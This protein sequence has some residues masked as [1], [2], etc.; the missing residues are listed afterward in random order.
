[1]TIKYKSYKDSTNTVISFTKW[2]NSTFLMA[3]PLNPENT[4]YKIYLQWVA[5]GGVTEA[6][7]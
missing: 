3:I 2:D 6:A 5:D 4:D 7:E 1:M